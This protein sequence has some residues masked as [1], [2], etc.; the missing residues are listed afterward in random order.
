MRQKL[1][2]NTPVIIMDE[3]KGDVVLQIADL[4][5]TTHELDNDTKRQFFLPIVPPLGVGGLIL[6]MQKCYLI[7]ML[8]KSI[9]CLRNLK[10]W[11]FDK[12]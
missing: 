5:V 6:Q 11:I 8:K 4:I 9:W 2:K 10:Y 3:Q 1:E 12:E 7:G